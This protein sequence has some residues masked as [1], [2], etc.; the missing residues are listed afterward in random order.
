MSLYGSLGP[1]AAV[2]T[3]DL[4]LPEASEEDAR[5]IAPGASA[6]AGA[7]ARLAGPLRAFA[8][9]HLSLVY[10]RFE[11]SDRTITPQLLNMYGLIGIRFAF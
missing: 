5:S 6:S 7:E 11:F 3:L 1:A 10:P 9:A 2:T 4:A 8:E